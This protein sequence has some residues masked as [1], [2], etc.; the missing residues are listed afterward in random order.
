M[1]CKNK[2][3]HE[4]KM[5]TTIEIKVTSKMGK[6]KQDSKLQGDRIHICD[7]RNMNKIK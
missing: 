5:K 6:R 7:L 1:G 3:R 4:I 2:E